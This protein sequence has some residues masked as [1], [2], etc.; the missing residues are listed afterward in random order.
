MDETTRPAGPPDADPGDVPFWPTQV[1][2]QGILLFL[3][4]G[5]LLTCSIL[6]PF[7]LHGAADPLR[8]PGAIKPAWYF[9]PVYQ[10][11]KYAP[12]PAGAIG[13]GGF[14]LT[15]FLWPFLDGAVATRVERRRFVPLVGYGV[16]LLV[17]VLGL[18]GKVSLSSYPLGER[19]LE[20]D[21]YGVPHLVGGE[22]AKR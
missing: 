19:R 15:M 6:A 1:L 3:L 11:L 8:T 7:G 9:L 22:A 10:F 17:I 16:L 14:L 21:Y 5:L 18:L 2:N 13:V 20:F 4:F 12:G